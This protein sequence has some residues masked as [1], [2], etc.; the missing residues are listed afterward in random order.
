MPFLHIC[1]IFPR[2]FFKMKLGLYQ[3]P[4]VD[5][6][7][8]DVDNDDLSKYRKQEQSATDSS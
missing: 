8:D 6:E 4:V 7:N 2:V 5:T 1:Y 3:Y